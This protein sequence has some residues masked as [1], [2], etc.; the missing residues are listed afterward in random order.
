MRRGYGILLLLLLLSIISIQFASSAEISMKES[1]MQSETLIAIISGNFLEN[2]ELS[3]V[4]FYRGWVEVP[5][6]AEMKEMGGDY[7][8][9]TKLGSKQAGNY[10]ISIENVKHMR[11]EVESSENIVAN[12]TITSEIAPFTIEPGFFETQSK[13]SVNIQNLKLTKLT[14]LLNKKETSSSQTAV[15]Q[16]FWASLFGGGSNS[17]TNST[18]E[19]KNY[20]SESSIELKSGEVGTINVE[21]SPISEPSL[22]FITLSSENLTYEIPIYQLASNIPVQIDENITINDSKINKSLNVSSDKNK[23]SGNSSIYSKTCSQMNGTLC[24]YDIQ[25]CLNETT[26]HAKDGNCCLTSCIEKETSN[27]GKIIGWVLILLAVAFV[28]WFLKTKYLKTKKGPPDLLKV[29]RGK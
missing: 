11:G 22:K 5:M 10:S 15:S 17:T 21:L 9:Y 4:N 20:T 27:A 19:I 29:A 23:T 1:Y 6:I 25:L 12:F 7:Y 2:I 13:F 14:V 8:V 26:Y 24:N 18:Q 3:D 28:L 16:G